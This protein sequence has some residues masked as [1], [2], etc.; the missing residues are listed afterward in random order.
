MKRYIKQ[1]VFSWNDR[2]R[3]YDACENDLYYVEGEILSLGKKLHLYRKSG[4][5]LAFIHQ[6]LLT[7]LPRY[8]ISRNG[9]DVAEVVRELTFFRPRYTVKG[10]GWTVS[11]DIFEHEYEISSGRRPIASVSKRWFSWGDTYEID[12]D[13]QADEVMVLAIVLVI[14]AVIEQN[15]RN[16]AS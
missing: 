16:H 14:D 11:G 13:D 2:F 5:E 9:V 12:I 10:P 1:K 6:K 3:I 15:Q 4:E 7:F 8:F